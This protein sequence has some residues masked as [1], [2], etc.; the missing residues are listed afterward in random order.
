MKPAPVSYLPQEVE[1][2]HIA[3]NL[4]EAMHEFPLQAEGQQQ[5]LG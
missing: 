4:V 2:A 3:A 5:N 1:V